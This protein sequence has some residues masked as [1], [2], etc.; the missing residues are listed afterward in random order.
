MGALQSSTSVF[1]HSDSDLSASHHL[2]SAW[3]MVTA[4]VGISLPD[5]LEP[6]IGRSKGFEPGIRRT[7]FPKR[8]P[9]SSFSNHLGPFTSLLFLVGPSRNFRSCG[10]SNGKQPLCERMSVPDPDD[11]FVRDTFW[12]RKVFSWH[13]NP[14]LSSHVKP[15]EWTWTR[16]TW[17][18]SKMKR[19]AR[20]IKAIEEGEM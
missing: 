4:E 14:F 2:P 10:G 11:I 1:C 5:C 9:F 18:N 6:R 13:K 3:H 16:Q 19:K 7:G 12:Q 20:L 17:Q 15:K 8:T